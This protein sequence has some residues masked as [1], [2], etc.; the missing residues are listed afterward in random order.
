MVQQDLCASFGKEFTWDLKAKMM[1]KKALDAGKVL[2]SELHLEGVI[3]PEEF[4]RRRE[5]KLRDLFPTTD[6]MPGDSHILR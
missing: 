1:G 6:L 2:V 5:E 3:T 4:I